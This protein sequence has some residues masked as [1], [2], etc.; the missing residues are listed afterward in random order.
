MPAGPPS[1]RPF[2]LQRPAAFA[3]ASPVCSPGRAA[4]LRVAARYASKPGISGE[5]V[6]EQL[7]SSR[8][9]ISIPIG[10]HLGHRAPSIADK[11]RVA[12]A[13]AK[14][15]DIAPIIAEIRAAGVTTLQ[16]IA[17]E[18][19]RRGIPTAA[20]RGQWQAVQVARVLR[21]L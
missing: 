12:R 20:G 8:H 7:T 6:A 15:A 16:G 10:R 13:V 9:I 18:L 17:D 1:G 21:R 19:N 14:A 3:A 2:A 11:A 4:N 5:R